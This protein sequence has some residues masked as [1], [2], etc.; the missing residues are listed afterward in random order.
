[1]NLC[2]FFLYWGM[3]GLIVIAMITSDVETLEWGI[4]AWMRWGLP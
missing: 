3:L 1:M 2:M 4:D